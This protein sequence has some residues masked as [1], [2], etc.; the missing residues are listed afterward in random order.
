M[1]TLIDEL[2]L[3]AEITPLDNDEKQN[4]EKQMRT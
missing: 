3:G 1:I 2:D 4:K